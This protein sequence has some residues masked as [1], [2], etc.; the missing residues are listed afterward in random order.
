DLLVAAK[1]DLGRL[2]VSSVSVDLKAQAAQAIETADSGQSRIVGLPEVAAKCI[3]DPARVRQ[4]IR[5][6][7]SNAIKYG[8]PERV[9]ETAVRD[10]FGVLEVRDNGAGV[11]EECRER[12]F[13]AYDR[14]DAPTASTNSLG[15]G[16]HISRGLADRM[17]GALTYR[18]ENGQ[19]I[20]ELR[21]PL[22]P[23][24]TTGP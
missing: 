3:G 13:N 20:F 8:G 5:N 1:S 12:I 19:S 7:L 15:L 9:I 21:M 2:E 6:L 16:L 4:I 18:Y 23:V 17:G 10:G 22:A 24:E 14:G 11:P